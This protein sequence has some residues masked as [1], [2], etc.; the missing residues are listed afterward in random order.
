[1]S[2][3]LSLKCGECEARVTWKKV[4]KLHTERKA[5]RKLYKLHYFSI[6]ITVLPFCAVCS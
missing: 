3:G 5:E 4:K 1:M 2:S 6:E